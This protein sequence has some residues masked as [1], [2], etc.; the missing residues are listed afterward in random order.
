MK[1]LFKT[2]STGI[3]TCRIVPIIEN[4]PFEFSET[5]LQNQD[6]LPSR[7]LGMTYPNFL[8]LSKAMGAELVQDD[9]LY[10][11][12]IFTKNKLTTML[13]RLLNLKS[14]LIVTERLEEIQNGE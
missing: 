5:D 4:W 7:I 8:E 14:Q 11:V 1:R 2:K 10:L 9:T 6:I 3:K 13:V 12:P